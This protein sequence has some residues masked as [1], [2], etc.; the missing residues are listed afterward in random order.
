MMRQLAVADRCSPEGFAPFGAIID[1]P[2]EAGQRQ[3][4]SD[5]LGGDAGLAPVFHV[6]NVPAT[7]LP[8]VVTRLERH[9]HA[10]QCFTP[11][12]VSRYLVTVTP[13]LP[14]GSPDLAGMQSF[15]LPGTKGVIYRRGV[16][17]AGATVLDRAGAFAVLMWRGA[18]DDDVFVEVAPTQLV[19]EGSNP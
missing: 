11:L 18:A 12:D 16:W 1:R 2:A 15:V 8:A 13:S 5:W 7:A 17:H 9:W 14:D 4:Y 10:A 19:L 6:N 3:F